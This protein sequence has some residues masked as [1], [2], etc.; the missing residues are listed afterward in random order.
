MAFKDPGLQSTLKLLCILTVRRTKEGKVFLKFLFWI[1]Q[2]H[3]SKEKSIAPPHRAT[4]Q[5]P[6]CWTHSWS[7]STCCPAICQH[8]CVLPAEL[9]GRRRSAAFLALPWLYSVSLLS[10]GWFSE[11]ASAGVQAAGWALLC[12]RGRARCTAG[13]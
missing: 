1:I 12:L 6:Q 2:T 5:L 10:Q 3:K 4:S 7:H 11:L 8:R 13:H 9:R